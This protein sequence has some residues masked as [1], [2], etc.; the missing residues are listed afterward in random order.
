[1]TFYSK[2]QQFSHFL[3]KIF[4]VIIGASGLFEA[5]SKA[6]LETTEILAQSF[7]CKI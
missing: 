1:M 7:T 4:S 6:I 5:F 3:N 2:F